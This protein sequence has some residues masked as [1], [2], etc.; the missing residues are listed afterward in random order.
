MCGAWPCKKSF[1]PDP[2]EELRK[3]MMEGVCGVV[4]GGGEPDKAGNKFP[5]TRKGGLNRLVRVYGYVFA[6]IYK[7]RKKKGAQGPVIINPIKKGGYRT[8]YPSPGCRR[9]RELYLLELAQKEM[10]IA[11][12]KM[13]ATDVLTE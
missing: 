10:G 13:L 5:T 6:A 2:E 3:D 12:A 9:A 11:G 8:G 4:R 7:W 1:S